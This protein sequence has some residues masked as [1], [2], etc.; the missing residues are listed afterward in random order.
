MYSAN[1]YSFKGLT[2]YRMR[3]K[4]ELLAVAREQHKTSLCEDFTN[5]VGVHVRLGDFIQGDVNGIQRGEQSRSLPIEWYTKLVMSIKEKLGKRIK[6][7]VFS[8]ADDNELE[9][10]L[11]LEG[12]ERKFYGSAFADMLALQQCKLIISTLSSFALWAV[13]LGDT[14]WIT[15]PS[16]LTNEM[17]KELCITSPTER[18]GSFNGELPDMDLT[19]LYS[20]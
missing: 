12:V 13:F 1:N 16:F 15:Y 3:I 17:A 20:I 4:Q 7:Y 11:T 8:D 18:K 6:F 10:L 19:T 5:V 2:D 14:Y 9:E